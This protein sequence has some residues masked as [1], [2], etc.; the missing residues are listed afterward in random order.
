MT[1]SGWIFITVSWS[2]ILGLFA[3]CLSRTFRKK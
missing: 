3:F 1:V 2:I